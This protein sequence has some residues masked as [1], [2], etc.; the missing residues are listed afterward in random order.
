MKWAV[1][2]TKNNQAVLRNKPAG[3]YLLY[4][5]KAFQEK[6]PRQKPATSLGDLIDLQ[7]TGTDNSVE[8][9]LWIR[10]EFTF[11]NMENQLGR[12]EVFKKEYEIF[13]GGWL[14]FY[15]HEVRCKKT[16][17]S[18]YFNWS[19]IDEGPNAGWVEI[20]IA[21]PAQKIC[22]SV[23]HYLMPATTE[24]DPPTP[25]APPPPEMNNVSS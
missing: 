14:L 6:F 17:H 5:E 7:N 19:D 20:Y 12:W 4:N 11:P 18:I 13:C 23:V 10:H 22:L 8:Y 24:T 25:P 15:D 1:P 16:D 2:D 21:P 9:R 3:N